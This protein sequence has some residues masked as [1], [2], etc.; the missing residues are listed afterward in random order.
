MASAYASPIWKQIQVLGMKEFRLTMKRT[1]RTLSSLGGVNKTRHITLHGFKSD[2]HIYLVPWKH[3]TTKDKVV[4]RPSVCLSDCH[5]LLLLVP[6]EFRGILVIIKFK[7]PVQYL[8][9]RTG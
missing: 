6:H 9:N 3:T 5:D 8:A 1:N 4:R 2:L 7:T